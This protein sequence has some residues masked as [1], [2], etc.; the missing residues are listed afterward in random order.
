M[1]G[2]QREV[3]K[4]KGKTTT[5]VIMDQ[6]NHGTRREKK[7]EDGKHKVLLPDIFVDCCQ[8]YKN[9]VFGKFL[10]LIQH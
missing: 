1:M 9:T 10:A 2:L 4:I 6:R 7:L 8:C 3:I 5:T